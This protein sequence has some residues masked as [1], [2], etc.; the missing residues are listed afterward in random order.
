MTTIPASPRDTLIQALRAYGREQAGPWANLA[1][2]W[3]NRQINAILSGEPLTLS[4]AVCQIDEWFVNE[5]RSAE[6]APDFTEAT[7]LIC[8]VVYT[9]DD[10]QY[11]TLANTDEELSRELSKIF[12]HPCYTEYLTGLT[13]WTLNKAG[14]HPCTLSWQYSNW[15]SDHYRDVRGKVFHGAR[16][17]ANFGYREDG[18]M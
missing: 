10:E 9:V 11:A 15:S 5:Q 13:V 17:I 1:Y 4:E 14:W 6:A 12:G 2:H 16:Q 8:V 7:R 18:A 3:S